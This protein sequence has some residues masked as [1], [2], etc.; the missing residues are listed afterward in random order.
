MINNLIDKCCGCSLCQTICPQKCIELV[1]KEDG[2]K[3]PQ[4]DTEKCIGCNLCE[5]LCPVI[6]KVPAISQNEGYLIR[7]KDQSIVSKSASGGFV[8]PIAEFV[9]SNE[10]TVYGA[11]FDSKWSVKHFGI[12][13]Y[14]EIQNIRGSKYVQS[15]TDFIYDEVARELKNGKMVLFTGTPCQIQAVT[16]YIKFK[17]LD[18]NLY[19][20]DVVCKGV[21]SPKVW[22]KY[23]EYQEEKNHSRIRKINFR[24][25]IHGYHSSNM[26]VEFENNKKSSKSKSDFYMKAYVDELLS[27][28]SCYQCAFKGIERCSDF[29]I[30]DAWHMNRLVKDKKDDDKGYTFLVTRSEKGKKI[31]NE[32]RDKYYIRRIDLAEAIKLDGCMVDG[33][34]KENSNRI[35]FIKSTISDGFVIANRKFKVVCFKDYVIEVIKDILYKLG[36]LRFVK[37]ILR[38]EKT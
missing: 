22:E 15:S 20:I 32:I 1:Y 7:A 4:I 19:T 11:G 5:K 38:S 18:K 21:G 12:T 27:R 13:K 9:I 10:G 3:Y 33:L 29:T 8:T 14:N 36:A 34:P 35:E 6:N 23:V 28:T 17:G 2:F 16:K 26:V 37:S 24:E 31:L 25:K 30:F